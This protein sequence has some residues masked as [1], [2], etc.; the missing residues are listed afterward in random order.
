MKWIYSRTQGDFFKYRLYSPGRYISWSSLCQVVCV[1]MWWHEWRH[2]MIKS[3]QEPSFPQRKFLSII[4]QRVTQLLV[5]DRS[6]L[7][8]FYHTYLKHLL[9]K[10]LWMDQISV[11]GSNICEWIIFIPHSFWAISHTFVSTDTPIFVLDLE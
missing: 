3:T 10:F 4:C 2:A 6:Y 5:W 9:L 1:H 8:W 7:F 11:S